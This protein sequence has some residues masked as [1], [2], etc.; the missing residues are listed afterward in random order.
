[1]ENLS[2]NRRTEIRTWGFMN[3][4]ARGAHADCYRVSETVMQLGQIE[5]TLLV[6]LPS[7]VTAFPGMFAW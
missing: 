2:Q 5:I 6:Q 7:S 4:N 1:M 3:R